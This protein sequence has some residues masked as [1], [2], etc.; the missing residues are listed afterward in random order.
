MHIDRIYNEYIKY[1]EKNNK[2]I[3]NIDNND[4]GAVS[5][6]LMQFA[7]DL[8]LGIEEIVHLAQSRCVFFVSY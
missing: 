4:I 5:H 6:I 2:P 1:F 3:A 7:Y 8:Y